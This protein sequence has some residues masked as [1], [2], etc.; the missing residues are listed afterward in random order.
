VSRCDALTP[1]QHAD[2]DANMAIEFDEHFAYQEAQARA[3]V[4]GKITPDEAQIVYT[5]L[6][7][8]GSE[9]NGGWAA[10][11]DLPTKVTV[12]MLMGELIKQR[13]GV[14]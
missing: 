12:T 3:H 5:S 11:T 6:G 13:L 7:E 2:L 10:G 1:E 14:R 8:V 9:S 4:E